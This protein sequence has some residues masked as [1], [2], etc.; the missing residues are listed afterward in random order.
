MLTGV[1]FSNSNPCSKLWFLSII[2]VLAHMSPGVTR[3]G[4]LQIPSTVLSKDWRSN[5][6][7]FVFC[8]TEHAFNSKQV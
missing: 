3:F 5:A 1:Y 8:E 4:R 7:E 2:K 6:S